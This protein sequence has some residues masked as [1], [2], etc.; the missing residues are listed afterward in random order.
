MATRILPDDLPID[1]PSK[2]EE[3][4]ER[5]DQG[6]IVHEA[7][8]KATTPE[9]VATA[10]RALFLTNIGKEPF[11]LLKS[12]LTPELPATKTIAQLKTVIRTNLIPAPSVA[13][14]AYKLSQMRQEPNELLNLF[15]S[16]VKIQAAK[17]GFEG[18]FDRMVRDKF[19]CGVRSE[20]LR[21]ALLSD[22]DVTTAAAAL[23]KA[24]VR[25]AN[26]SAA[27]EMQC[28]TV[29][30]GYSN[31]GQYSNQNSYQKS[32]QS[33]YQ[34]KF[35]TRKDTSKVCSRCTLRGHLSDNC[36]T[37]CRECGG[38]G[39]IQKFCPKRGK[40]K[41]TARQVEDE[42]DGFAESPCEG[43]AA[44]SDLDMRN[45]HAIS[46][47]SA[48]NDGLDRRVGMVESVGSE[49]EPISRERKVGDQISA[50][51]S[52]ECEFKSTGERSGANSN[53]NLDFSCN[54]Q[55]LQNSHFIEQDLKIPN[56][57]DKVFQN[58]RDSNVEILNSN[59]V[60]SVSSRP[61]I[62]VLVNNK[63]V[64][65]ELDTGASVTCMSRDTY[66]RF[67][68]SSSNLIPDNRP[69]KVANGEQVKHLFRTEV[70]V[71]FRGI[72]RKLFLY[73][74]ESSFPTLFGRDWISVFFGSDWLSRLLDT[75]SVDTAS[76]AELET[77]FIQE[78]RK[79]DIFKPGLGTVKGYEAALDLKEGH[80][81]KFCKART[82]PFA[83]KDSLGK[84]L[85]RMEAEGTLVRVDFSD[86]ASPVV[87]SI[88]SD[89]SIRICGDY[90][91]TVN[92]N[93]DTKVYPLPVVEDCF[94]EMS[95]GV[96]FTKLDIKSAYNNL[97]LREQDQLLTTINTHQ[98]LYKWTRLPYG[99]SSSSAIFQSV[100]D[101]VL[102]GLRGVTCRVDDIL[103]TGSNN[104]EHMERVREVVKRLETA[105]F[106]CGWE[107]SEFL[108]DQVIY[109]GYEVSR[110]GIKPRRNKVE[111]IEKAEYPK[112]LS[113]L[114][115]FLGAVQ[116]YGRHIPNM[117]TIIEP[118]NRLRTGEWKFGS[119]E[120]KSFD[121]LKKLLASD[122]ILT[123]YN[124]NL[125]IRVDTDASKYG[126]GAVLS[127][128]D[129]QG[130]DKPIEFI[131]RTL[132]PAE[133]KYSQI[134]KEALGIVWAVKRFHRYV[135][136]R[137]FELQTDHK[138]LE[139]IYHPHKSIP[140][141]G[142]NR[143]Q[144]WAL[145]LSH[146]TYTIKFR[147][148][149]K[150]AN[151]DFCSRFPLRET[152]D[153]TGL[154]EKED[155]DV[156][157]M[158]SL[159]EE[160]EKPLLDS[161]LIAKYSKKDPAL[162][163]AIYSTLEGWSEIELSS[164]HA[165]YTPDREGKRQCA[166]YNSRSENG[167]P[168]ESSDTEFMAYYTRRNELSVE[169]GCLIW[170]N[171]VV[172]PRDLRAE[173]LKLIHATHMGASAMKSM[174]RNHV[175]WPKLDNELER[176]AKICESC[177]LNQRMP[178][179]SVPHPWK[180]STEPWE[181]CHLD[182]A[183]PFMGSMWLLLVDSYSKW[184][185]VVDMKSSTTSR[186]TIRELRKLFSRFGIP[187]TLVSDNGTQ[188]TS[189]EFESFCLKNGINHIKIPAYHPASNGQ[190]E[191]IVGKFKLAMKKM[192]SEKDMGL[193][194]ANWLLNYHNTP[195]S[196]TNVEPSVRMFG[197]RLRSAISLCHPLNN[198]PRHRAGES[199]IIESEATLR[200]FALGKEVLYRDVLQK[201][202]LRGVITETSDKQY[203]I[204]TSDGSKVTKHVDHIR[205][206]FRNEGESASKAN[207][208]VNDPKPSVIEPRIEN[209]PSTL[210]APDLTSDLQ[211]EPVVPDSG[212]VITP[213]LTPAP[214]R[215]TRETRLPVKLE[216]RKLGGD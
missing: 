85:D 186:S 156:C 98:G 27:H 50:G 129:E 193:S 167:R 62:K 77:E 28:N 154:G 59:T 83:I 49:A 155:D 172:I 31:N 211:P 130:R 41:H 126:I 209:E 166:A 148:T 115:S 63:Q 133:R 197:R 54:K 145:T 121:K 103:I 202:W 90:K 208:S 198:P 174:A 180:P 153:E 139:L 84:E 110:A 67:G 65:F 46:K 58:S 160:D 87:P 101:A 182:F 10:K 64:Q 92:P 214:R 40:G 95:G 23:Q 60:S 66:N 36:H 30:K 192:S 1:D 176:V 185:E 179:K 116:Y 207:E 91:S 19:I 136:A 107:K 123:F 141:M 169:S 2:I 68:F 6:C 17:C 71:H 104:T 106:R 38:V 79:S 213:A 8:L 33:S 187:K 177:Q 43:D 195:H 151:A 82:V 190:A 114:V 35:K 124:P 52:V 4:F 24:Q 149:K 112:C 203:V 102:R 161:N 88:K 74:V 15:M 181:R 173:M 39:H 72:L 42:C 86:Y 159:Y 29:R 76:E 125:P 47:I 26:F 178:N 78:M 128:V 111:T 188:L 105:G 168:E 37:K 212:T 191:S 9:A 163:K 143:I 127:H 150:H 45:I 53:S 21:S 216:Y 113:E 189:A 109:L 11:S 164:K 14:E 205:E 57:N 165:V 70:T 18:A 199:Q 200:R 56:L 215:S 196:T 3:W 80:R 44:E 25:E 131:S 146:Y 100:M 132:T 157:T 118:L 48:V 89:K 162:A 184:I 5:F 93:L 61:M 210:S 120:K 183:G 94:A 119:K 122:R 134:E 206:Y 96:K 117:S 108:K 137:N 97:M 69:L 204:T 81:P 138:P 73:V 22:P 13:S 32:S 142:A 16:R 20:K 34:K 144:R 12:Y 152:S 170:G 194:L 75:Y 55:V 51:V 171:R 135:Y 201:R 158:F 140:E 99:I 147:P 175:W 7:V